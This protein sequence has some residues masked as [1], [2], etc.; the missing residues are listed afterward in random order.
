[1]KKKIVAALIVLFILLSGVIMF[2]NY[3]K[4]VK[5]EYSK[6]IIKDLVRYLS[7]EKPIETWKIS[8]GT[9]DNVT[10][11]LYEDGTLIISGTG[12]MTK[13]PWKSSYLKNIKKIIIESGITGLGSISDCNLFGNCENLKEIKADENSLYY[14]SEDGVLFNKDKTKLLRYP[15]AKEK[16]E[17]VVPDTVEEIVFR[18]FEG[19]K[20]LKKIVIPSSVTEANIT[21]LMF[22]N[23]KSLEEIV[24][25]TDNTVYSSENGVLF[26]KDKTKLLVYPPKKEDIIYQVPSTVTGIA[27]QAFDW[28]E[29]LSKIIMPP[30]E[31]YYYTDN[32]G[33]PITSISLQEVVIDPS[34]PNLCSVD[35]VVF[36]KEQTKL[37]YFPTG[38]KGT[39]SISSGVR[40]I[41]ALAFANSK[42]TNINIP[43]NVTTIGYG[44]FDNCTNLTSVTVKCNSYAKSYMEE[45][46]EYELNINHITSTHLATVEPTCLEDGYSLYNCSC[47]ENFETDYIDALGHSYGDW[48]IEEATFTTKGYKYRNCTRCQEK[49]EE[50]IAKIKVDISLNGDG[51]IL[52]ELNDDNTVLTISGRGGMKNYSY[53]EK[54]QNFPPW[55]SIREQ[56]KSIVIK[57]ESGNNVTTIG[58]NAFYNCTALTSV[59]IP[60]SVIV[61]GSGAFLD[62]SSLIS[63]AIPNSSA[64]IGPHVFSGCT[65]L[66]SVTLPEQLKIIDVKL[67]WNC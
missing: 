2:F 9:S 33:F 4:I 35:G 66:T 45:N 55:Y 16:E 53:E 17:Y 67:F 3:A 27:Y 8:A 24:V 18:S 49:E 37:L 15:P 6:T 60:N 48:I 65:S 30:L 12:K 31:K 20:N 58:T 63:V 39:Y 50:E 42:L 40:E 44:V 51:S 7:S 25:D 21:N 34:D 19:I 46:Y 38:R 26:N 32:Y 59:T 47:G 28:T 29:K 43:N 64:E 52:A 11:A 57:G 23:D 14:T 1:M 5:K 62:C 10:A 54:Y 36:N 56:I 41:E 22:E 13:E 61:V